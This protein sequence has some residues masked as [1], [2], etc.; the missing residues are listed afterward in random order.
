MAIRMALGA[1][2]TAMMKG[3]KVRPGE[4]QPTLNAMDDQADDQNSLGT[5]RP[6]TATP[7]ALGRT[8]SA[9]EG[10]HH[11]RWTLIPGNGGRYPD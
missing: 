11:R 1:S 10:A 7:M 2:R 9:H 5:R 6:P 8:L 3:S 4:G